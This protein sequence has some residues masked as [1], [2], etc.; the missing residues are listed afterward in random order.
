TK[1][2]RYGRDA[3][4]SAAGVVTGPTSKTIRQMTYDNVG[5]SYSQTWINMSRACCGGQETTIH[6]A[7]VDF[8]FDGKDELQIVKTVTGLDF[9]PGSLTPWQLYKFDVNG[10]GALASALDLGFP[11]S[12]IRVFSPGRFIAG[13]PKD[14]PVVLYSWETNGDGQIAQTYRAKIVDVAPGLSATIGECPASHPACQQGLSI[15]PRDPYHLQDLYNVTVDH[16]GD[17]IDVL[18]H[19]GG[20]VGG[21]ID[22]AANGRQAAVTEH[23]TYKVT[24]GSWGPVDIAGCYLVSYGST[25]T[26]GDVNGDG[27]TD[28]IYRI[29]GG[30]AYVYLSTGSGYV[31]A[32]TVSWSDGLALKDA[33]NDGKVDLYLSNTVY[34]LSSDLTG[35]HLM[36]SNYTLPKYYTPYGDFNGDGLPDYYRTGSDNPMMSQAGSGNPNLLRSVKL[37]TGGVVSVDYTPST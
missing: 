19:I 3:T 8:D 37:E 31:A 18:A 22:L 1:V 6:E 4:V 32:T 26:L 12:E 15:P 20:Y 34:S 11:S 23:G 13:K 14:V 36:P 2:D 35:W 29:E 30:T 28:L 24:N 17:G 25:C 7:A 10:V 21:V 5:F 33:D 16:D 27:A 9:Y